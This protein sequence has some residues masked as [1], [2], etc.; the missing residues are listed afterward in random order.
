VTKRTPAQV[1]QDL[2]AVGFTPAAAVTMTEI[3]GAESNYNDAALGDVGLENNTWGPSF[4]LFQIRTQK[5]ATGSGGARD[6]N[7]LTG[8]DLTQARA[9]YAISSQGTNFAPWS[10]WTSGAYTKFS[11]TVRAALGSAAPAT[12][13]TPAAAG[14][15]AGPFPTL[16]PAWLPWNIPSDVGNAAASTASAEFASVRNVVIEVLFGGLGIALVGLGVYGLSAPRLKAA[17]RRVDQAAG[18]VAKVATL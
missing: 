7:A 6:I 15:G 13:V 2:L 18:T 17:G 14:G 9:A 1:Y 12:T 8:D 4:G 3:A 5:S 11:A 16:G 10:T